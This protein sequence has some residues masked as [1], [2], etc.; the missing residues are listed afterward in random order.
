[1]KY[2]GKLTEKLVF[3]ALFAAIITVMTAY[4]CHIPVGVNGGYIHLGDV[5]IYLAA[6]ILPLPWA[7]GAAAVGAGL[8]DLLT[9]PLWTPAT[10]IIKVLVCLCFTSRK[11]AILNKRNIAANGASVLITCLGYYLAEGIILGWG[12]AFFASVIPNLIQTAG[13]TAAYILIAGALD[14]AGFKKRFT[15]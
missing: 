13:N 10:I 2:K 14:K 11:P 1:M 3:S 7:C 5:F 8:A 9:A 6:S 4:I 12:A 15:F